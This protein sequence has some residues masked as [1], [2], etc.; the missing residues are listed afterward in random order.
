[1]DR[2]FVCATFFCLMTCAC[3]SSESGSDGAA[4]T[5]DNI[6]MD[7]TTIGV[8]TTDS[9]TVTV[10]YSDPD[11]DVVRLSEQLSAPGFSTRP[12]NVMNVDGSGQKQG[13]HA[14]VLQVQV[15]TKAT[16]DLS[17]WLTD[18]KGHDSVKVSRSIVA[19]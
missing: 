7:K 17:F 19:Q 2:S 18:A 6:T 8:G 9:I 13:R 14:M 10:D 11:A 1:M 3:S 12:P 4:P 15:P 5:I 16:L